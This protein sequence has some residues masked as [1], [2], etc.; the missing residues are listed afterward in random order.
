[1]KEK[2]GGGGGGGWWDEECAEKKRVVRRAL[3][4]WRKGEERGTRYKKERKEYRELC[5]RKRKE[6]NER[7][8]KEIEEIRSEEMIWKVVNKERKR[9]TRINEGIEMGEWREYFKGMMGG[10]EGRVIW[11]GRERGRSEGEGELELAEIRKVIGRLRDGKAIG[12]D[13]VPNEVWRYGREEV[14][15]WGL[16]NRV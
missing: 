16:C 15:R 6:E 9:R 3:R 11:G 13:E 4:R 14:V 7:W 2:K 10:V 5:E 12:A 8:E 1:V